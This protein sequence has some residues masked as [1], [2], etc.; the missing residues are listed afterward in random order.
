MSLLADVT[1]LKT[2]LILVAIAASLV[3]GSVYGVESIISKHDDKNAIVLQ[4][5]ADSQAKANVQFQQGIKL[6]LDSIAA[7]NAQL[8]AENATLINALAA[9]QVVEKK[10]PVAVAS[11]TSLEVAA[12]LKKATNG[13]VGILKSPDGDLIQLDLPTA[14]GVLTSV[15]LVPLLQQDKTDLEK[16]N[17]LLQTEVANGVKALDLERTAHANDNTTN[18]GTIKARDAEI[19]AVKAECRKSK[20]KWFGIGVV[21]GFVGR[22]FVGF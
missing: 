20:L 8:A 1:W 3:F 9:R 17:G 13:T 7:Q 22:G 6:Q 10:I 11:E 5:L 14:K 2:H 12:D 4:T 21:V 15:Q 18:A 19:V 16:S